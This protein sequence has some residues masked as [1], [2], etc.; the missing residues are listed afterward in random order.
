MTP[1]RRTLP[2]TGRRLHAPTAI[3]A[4]AVLLA[5]VAGTCLC[6]M[7]P[8]TAGSHDCCEGGGGAVL[9]ASRDC[10]LSRATAGAPLLVVAASGALPQAA[11]V[12]SPWLHMPAVP[13]MPLRAV[14]PSFATP[15]ILRI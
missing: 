1:R 9:T 8:A 2:G 11:D 7:P 4:V 13:L 10:C 12:P 15:S 14:P 3:L 5:S 6:V